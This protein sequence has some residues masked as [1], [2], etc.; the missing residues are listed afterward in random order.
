MKFDI[1]KL[2]SNLGKQGLE[3]TRIKDIVNKAKEYSEYIDATNLEN[4]DYITILKI[5]EYAH[6]CATNCLSIENKSKW[7][8]IL[9]Y[10]DDD[11]KIWNPRTFVQS[12]LIGLPIWCICFN[13]SYW[14]EHVNMYHENVY[15]V[16]NVLEDSIHQYT[17]CLVSPN[18]KITIYD[19]EH[20]RLDGMQVSQYLNTLG[21]GKQYLKPKQQLQENKQNT[22]I[23]KNMKNQTIKLNESQLRKMI[24]KSVKKV[25]NEDYINDVWYDENRNDWDNNGESIQREQ[26]INLIAATYYNGTSVLLFDTIEDAA[27]YVYETNKYRGWA[28]D[29]TIENLIKDINSENYI[30]Y[31]GYVIT[32]SV[33]KV[34]KN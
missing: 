22:K 21:N 15:M 23:N 32:K 30:E 25:L 10:S 9:L 7:D 17:C 31:G 2:Y 19:R 13:E 16:Y 14:N 28:E 33:Y 8:S 27:N 1:N 3:E 11:V 18:G 5:L 12:S 24:K 4:K 26:K 29:D 20:N 6:F 34:N